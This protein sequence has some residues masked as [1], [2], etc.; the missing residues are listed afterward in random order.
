M[1]RG[2]NARA[3]ES[4]SADLYG[5][6]GRPRITTLKQLRKFVKRLE[7]WPDDAQVEAASGLVLTVSYTKTVD[8]RLSSPKDQEDDQ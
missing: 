2:W 6:L 3:Y 8:E 4:R 7:K 5:Q 1:R